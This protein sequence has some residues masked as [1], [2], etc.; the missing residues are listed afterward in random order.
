MCSFKICCVR[1]VQRDHSLAIKSVEEHSVSTV[2]V[3][4]A[5]S[6]SPL[7]KQRVCL[8]L[9]HEI[10]SSVKAR[11][12]HFYLAI[13]IPEKR[14]VSYVITIATNIIFPACL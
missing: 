1:T 6:V 9:K 2:K 14:S 3:K 4:S 11:P 7:A 12:Y 10:S 5:L 8:C 13:L